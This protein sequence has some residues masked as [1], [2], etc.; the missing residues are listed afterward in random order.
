[1]RAS[2]ETELNESFP[3]H[4]V[5]EWIGNSMQIAQRH[6]LSVTEDHFTR[7]LQNPVQQ[8]VARTRTA[9]VSRMKKPL[10][11]RGLRHLAT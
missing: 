1:M 6:Y 10:Y 9:K 7:A 5:C 3:S 4:V 8:A 2:R 11:Y